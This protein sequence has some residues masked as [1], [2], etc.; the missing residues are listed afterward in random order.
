M[1][2]LF[3]FLAL[4]SP[5]AGDLHA[6]VMD[7]WGGVPIRPWTTPAEGETAAAMGAL[8]S[9][10]NAS[11]ALVLGDNFDTHGV[12]DEHDKRFQH[13]FEDVFSAPSLQAEAGFKFKVCA[14][15][16]DHLGNVSG[17]IEY[18]KSSQ[19]WEFPSL[20]HT[21]SAPLDDGTADTAQFVL[22]DTVVLSAGG[23]AADEQLLWLNR[24]LSSSTASY[25][26]VGGH[27]PV[28][29]VCEHGPNADMQKLVK[30]LLEQHRVQAYLA[31]HDHCEEHIVDS[32]GGE[33][34]VHYHV[35]GAANQNQGS[36]AHKGSVPDKDVLFLDLVR[37]RA[38]G[39]A[40]QRC[41]SRFT[42]HSHSILRVP[43]RGQGSG[44]IVHELEGGFASMTFD[45]A[46]L[47]IS[48]YRT[49]PVIMGKTQLM[50]T[51]PPIPKRH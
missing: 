49:R 41:F 6:L 39:A 13:T 3:L 1:I 12:T 18:S 42:L 2:G 16:H 27:F 51:A 8:A 37:P 44:P 46:G 17:Q 5:A 34:T 28:W 11:F 45:A 19:R 36:H 47:T 22:I 9:D 29:S 14:G 43:N 25:L 31:G 24:T 40:A 21:W 48:H 15:N 30:P 26:V 7:D 33:G 32:S 50:Y 20:Y 38:P 4:L 23:P 35:V 10:L